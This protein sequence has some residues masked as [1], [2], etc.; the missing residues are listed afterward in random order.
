MATATVDG[1]PV[2]TR[3]WIGGRRVA[4]PET[5]DGELTDKPGVVLLAPG[6]TRAFAMSI[7]VLP[8]G[9]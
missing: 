1:V 5:F 6:V 8:R 7:S 4:S 2:D 9:S 3:H